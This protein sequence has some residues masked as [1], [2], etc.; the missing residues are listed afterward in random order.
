MRSE[1]NIV[2]YVTIT[3]NMNWKASTG[4]EELRTTSQ[5]ESTDIQQTS[6]LNNVYI[7]YSRIS[8]TFS[9]ET[10]NLVV[11]SLNTTISKSTGYRP[12]FDF[13]QGNCKFYLITCHEGTRGSRDIPPPFL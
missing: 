9:V 2:F 7:S 6:V 10:L 13:S 12:Y 3:G 8:R 1:S 5:H 4:P 11:L